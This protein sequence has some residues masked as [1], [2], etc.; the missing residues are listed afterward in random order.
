[1]VEDRPIEGVGVGNFRTS[2]V[3]N[4]LEPGVLRRS[5]IILDDRKVAHNIYLQL[6]AE[7]GAVGLFAFALTLI[8]AFACGISVARTFERIGDPDMGKI[9][10]GA[11]VGRAGVLA[12]NSFS[13]QIF[14]KPLW[15]ML[16]LCPALLAL[17]QS[18][19]PPSSMRRGSSAAEVLD[20]GRTRHVRRP[21]A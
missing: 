6:F 8:F 4:L 18:S 13:S 15:L 9:A 14:L 12:V 3:D 5:E 17:A 11:L 21:P 1:M 20:S 19:K 2:L 7:T 16:A 10:R